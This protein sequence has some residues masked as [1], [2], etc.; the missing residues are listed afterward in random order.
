ML[1]SCSEPCI[2]YKNIYPAK[3]L[4]M[5]TALIFAADIEAEGL[6]LCTAGQN[7]LCNLLKALCATPCDDDLCLWLG[8]F[9][10]CG[11]SDA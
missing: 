6:A 9:E 10:S 2:V 5:L 11:T 7:L 8:K 1:K 3:G 4:Q